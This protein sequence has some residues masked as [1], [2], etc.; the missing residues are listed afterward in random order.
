MPRLIILLLPVVALIVLAIQNRTPVIALNFLGGSLPALPFGLLLAI[1]AAIGALITLVLYGLVGLR[2]PPES[3]YKPMGRRVPYPEGPGYGPAPSGSPSVDPAAPSAY[4]A[5]DPTSSYTSA[6]VDEPAPRDSAPS[7]PAPSA[8]SPDPSVSQDRVPSGY[9]P[10]SPVPKDPVPKD[11]ASTDSAPRDLVQGSIS[12]D[13]IPGQPVPAAGSSFLGS[14]KSNLPFVGKQDN[15]R[16]HSTKK[17][18]DDRSIGDDWGERRTTEQINDWEAAKPS[19]VEEGVGNL[20][21]LGKSAST[22][23]GR[24]ADDIASGWNNSNTASRSPASQSEQYSADSS[25]SDSRAYHPSPYEDELDRGWENFDDGYDNLPPNPSTGS[26]RPESR[27][28]YGDSLYG[29]DPYRREATVADDYDSDYIDTH[30]PSDEIGPDGVYEAD[31]RVIVPPSKPLDEPP[32][33]EAEDDR[34]YS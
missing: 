29:D 9:T 12:D 18:V 4:P 1:A 7:S 28:I 26:M 30:Q 5:A 34:Y 16:N 6:F 2:R 11:Y 10:V 15:S 17:S 27:R 20:F 14:L 13:P 22:N 25:Y 32:L 19:V 8:P 23:V 24:I 3:K 33:D 21:R 31:Y